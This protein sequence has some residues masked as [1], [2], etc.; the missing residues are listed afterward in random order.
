MMAVCLA[1]LSKSLT[2]D[3]TLGT[4]ANWEPVADMYA[5]RLFLM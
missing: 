4:R 2:D 1:L 3:H 5:C